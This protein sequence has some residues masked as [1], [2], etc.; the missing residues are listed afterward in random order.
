MD[1]VPALLNAEATSILGLRTVPVLD[2]IRLPPQLEAAWFTWISFIW[3]RQGFVLTGTDGH[4]SSES[5]SPTS[6]ADSG[7][8]LVSH[9]KE[10]LSLQRSGAVEGRPWESLLRDGPKCPKTSTCP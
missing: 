10:L 7:C 1:P 8:G 9:T 5:A 6:D 4:A 2:G 3:G